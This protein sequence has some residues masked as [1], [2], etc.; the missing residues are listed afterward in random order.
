MGGNAFG[1]TS[2]RLSATK[3]NQFVGLLTQSIKDEYNIDLHMVKSYS[4]KE[5]FGDA[6]F[7]ISCTSA[8]WQQFTEA[9]LK[10]ADYSYK[11]GNVVSIGYNFY[12]VDLPF[13]VDYIYTGDNQRALDLAVDYFAYNDLGNLIGRIAKSL[14][15]RYGHK[16][17]YYELYSTT[18][19][20]QLH[21]KIDTGLTTE[22]IHKLLNLDYARYCQGFE[23]PE[24]IFKFVSASQYFNSDF[25]LFEN[26]N[27]VSRIRD[28]KRKT[29]T[30]F[31]EWCRNNEF[32]APIVTK[33]NRDFLSQCFLL[34][35]LL[36]HENFKK[37]VC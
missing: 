20:N 24:D 36:K 4:S 32:P 12:G 25:F 29:Y 16:G 6:D 35:V 22:Q 31:L 5:S 34:E 7:L 27:H 23:T 33:E 18:K 3:Y 10:D 30:D 8:Q 17:L 2:A 21:A 15:F 28:R 26:V 11:N 1:F 9:E 13:Q 14:G 37:I 19:E